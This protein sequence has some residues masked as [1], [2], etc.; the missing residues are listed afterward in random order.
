MKR[1]GFLFACALSGFIA[2][3]M[4]S[5][6]ANNYNLLLDPQQTYSSEISRLE[7]DL[8]SNTTNKQTRDKLVK[9]YCDKANQAINNGGNIDDALNDYRM[10]LY[11]LKYYIPVGL[12]YDDNTKASEIDSKIKDLLAKQQKGVSPDV[13]F[14]EAKRLRGMGQFPQ[15]VVEYKE[16]AK[17]QSLAKSSYEAIGDI[18]MV[19]SKPLEAAKNY[20]ECLKINS[21]DAKMHLKLARAL[22][23]TG[24]MESA[25]QEYT[26]ALND[27]SLQEEVAPVVE[28]L[29]L[30]KISKNPD[31]PNSYIDLGRS[32]E[33]RGKYNDAM[34]YYTK[35]RDVDPSNRTA[36][37]NIA[38]VQAKQGD[39]TKA[40]EAYDNILASN[41][42]NEVIHYD[43]AVA[44]RGL[45]QYKPAMDE[46][47]YALRIDPNY[48]E[49]KILLLK[50]ID[51]DLAMNE[52]LNMLSMLVEANPQDE[53][54]I[55]VYGNKLYRAQKDFEAIKQYDKVIAINPKN[56]DAYIN[57]A[58]LY[59][60][61]NDINNAIAA[62][63][64]GMAANPGNAALDKVLKD[65]SAKQKYAQFDEALKLYEQGNYQGALDIYLT[66]KNP[67]EATLLNIGGCYY[68][69]QDYDK[70][71]E[72][73]NK[74]LL[75]NPK[76]DRALLYI[77]GSYYS[78]GDTQKAV[79]YYKKALV[80]KPN[81]K[82]IK[83][84]LNIANQNLGDDMLEKALALYNEGKF[85][86]TY[87]V[88]NQILK[89]NPT[90]A[91]AY[92]YRALIYD[93]WKKYPQ[94][95]AD[96]KKTISYMPELDTAYYS[97]AVDYDTLNDYANARSN[98]QK[99]LSMNQ[100]KSDTYTD[101]AKSRV[102]ELNRILT[103]K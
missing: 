102:S 76:N 50:I 84:A 47:V 43:K 16:A 8:R 83:E 100:G 54:V 61:N 53:T 14:K 72:Y 40:I 22:H 95:I 80:L 85:N 52:S 24:N 46:L 19:M 26:L 3:N 70:S 45:K 42:N 88:L 5:Y 25:L 2:L 17:S 6:A 20:D 74:A 55:M 27:P 58:R 82:E 75:K 63:K 96:Y 34:T 66:D 11:Y 57:K 68:G 77:G 33:K 21:K 89:L 60:R 4:C 103:K 65:V 29:S 81:D 18:M 73:Y 86:E 35:A 44:L 39:Y 87:S 94:A 15:A 64:A 101:Y 69:L 37:V 36:L 97:I 30:D 91:Y 98:Y 31:D 10:A 48:E 51:E 41:P 90:S 62:A 49:A 56:A 9:I 13:R 23:K 1:S 79:E 38:A 12:T 92:Y 7:K 28:E 59:E 99:F 67:S 93:E 32:Y 78:K 71:I